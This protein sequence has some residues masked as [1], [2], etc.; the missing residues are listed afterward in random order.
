MSGRER[1]VLSLIV[2]GLANKEIADR[3]DLSVRTIEKHRQRIMRKLGI[4]K[5]TELVKFAITRGF[6]NLSSV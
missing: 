1:Q 5:A 3:F 4:H 2:E 6:V